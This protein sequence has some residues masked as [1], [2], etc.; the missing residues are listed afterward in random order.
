M[1]IIR[2]LEG[3]MVDGNVV[4]RLYQC[5]DLGCDTVL[6]PSIRC[7]LWGKLGK[8]YKGSLAIPSF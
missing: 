4:P 8:D 6:S 5:Q 1:P 3:P 2:Q 7:Y